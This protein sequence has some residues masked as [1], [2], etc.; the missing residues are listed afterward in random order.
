MSVNALL[1]SLM[2]YGV[3]NLN[4]IGIF[5]M[6]R[7]IIIAPL[8]GLVLGDLR[9]GIILGAS[10]EAAFLGIIGTGGARPADPTVGT[11]FGTAV[12]I[13]SNASAEEALSIAVPVAVLAMSIYYLPLTA[14]NPIFYVAA[15]KAAAEGDE[16]KVIARWMIIGQVIM[17]LLGS[18]AVFLGVYFGVNAVNRILEVLPKVIIT[19]LRAAGSIL[20][21]VG[22]ALLLNMLFNKK[23]VIFFFVGAVFALYLS[24]PSI[25]VAVIAIAVGIYTF[26]IMP[27]TDAS[28]NKGTLKSDDEEFLN[29]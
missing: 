24:L 4:L 22:F 21:A 2:Y 6:N 8:V 15:Q 14:I 3:S 9:T 7:P 12:A 13:L 1:V 16:K 18:V 25:A 10:F 29:G 27:G 28:G 26:F 19:G 23:I 17:Y 11:A 20:P 5:H